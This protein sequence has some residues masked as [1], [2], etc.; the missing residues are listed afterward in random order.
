MQRTRGCPCAASLT[1]APAC[2]IGLT[3]RPLALLVAFA[4]G[5]EAEVSSALLHLRLGG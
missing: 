3:I 1:T 4:F 5:T 2:V